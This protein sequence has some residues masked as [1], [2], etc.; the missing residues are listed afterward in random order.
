MNP[1]LLALLFILFGVA[2]TVAFVQTEKLRRLRG[3]S[4]SDD[5]STIPEGR[6]DSPASSSGARAHKVAGRTV[7]GRSITMEEI[8]A[9]DAAGLYDHEEPF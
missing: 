8:A 2:V 4:L 5:D 3:D 6:G 7:Y 1:D 9:N